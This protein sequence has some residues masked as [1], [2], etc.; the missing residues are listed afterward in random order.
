MLVQVPYAINNTMCTLL[1]LPPPDAF[2][3]AVDTWSYAFE[4]SDG[5]RSTQQGLVTVNVQPVNDAP[6]NNHTRVKPFVCGEF[7]DR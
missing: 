7:I 1:Y 3:S 4:Y 5:S 6:N 2:G